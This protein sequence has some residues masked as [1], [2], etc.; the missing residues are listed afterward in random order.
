M[1]SNLASRGDVVV[2]EVAVVAHEQHSI[3]CIV[4]F[5][6]D[7]VDFH[8]L[9]LDPLHVVDCEKLARRRHA[10]LDHLRHALQQDSGP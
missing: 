2:L 9:H 7:R 4:D 1:D 5:V 10:H 3:A 6:G 8:A